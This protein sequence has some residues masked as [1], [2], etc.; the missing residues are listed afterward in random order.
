MVER[1]SRQAR[2]PKFLETEYTSRIDAREVAHR[3]MMN[4]APF[5]GCDERGYRAYD[6]DRSFDTQGI[7]ALMTLY[8][9][10][11]RRPTR[12][13]FKQYAKQVS[14]VFDE[15]AAPMMVGICVYG[16]TPD[17]GYGVGMR[18]MVSS[19]SLVFK[20]PDKSTSVHTVVGIELEGVFGWRYHRE[21]EPFYTTSG[22]WLPNILA[23]RFVHNPQ[24]AHVAKGTDFSPLS[25]GMQQLADRKESI[26]APEHAA[27]I[28]HLLQETTNQY[29]PVPIRTS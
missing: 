8:K 6:E 11:D 10:P 28:A 22:V 21:K 23:T 20:T 7:N 3:I 2:E 5:V 17:M 19:A 25:P 27:H 14:E 18:R 1:R 4:G 29:Q 16:R 9:A 24:V 26:E 13:S 15:F 12:A